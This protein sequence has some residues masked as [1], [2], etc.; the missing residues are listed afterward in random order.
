[1]KINEK[2]TEDIR[3]NIMSSSKE[4]K[5][6]IDKYIKEIKENLKLGVDDE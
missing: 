3:F 2:Y 5:E 4:I 6:K 1:M